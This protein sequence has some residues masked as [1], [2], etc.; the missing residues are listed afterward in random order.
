MTSSQQFD[1]RPSGGLGVR[2]EDLS[3]PMP[4]RPNP[5]SPGGLSV[6]RQ[7]VLQSRI[8]R[9]LELAVLEMGLL[10]YGAELQ[11]LEMIL[12]RVRGEW[13]R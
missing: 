9:N 8:V 11:D 13:D 3:V 6:H 10:G 2:Q 4:K 12:H 1:N 7:Q 5:D